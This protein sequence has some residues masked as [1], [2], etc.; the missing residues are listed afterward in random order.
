MNDV[1]CYLFCS[2]DIVHKGFTQS[3]RCG[4]RAGEA[5]YVQLHS[6]G[7]HLQLIDA[8]SEGY[9]DRGLYWA[10]SSP[11]VHFGF[12]HLLLLTGV[13]WV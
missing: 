1:D 2:F 13:S 12:P 6:P 3:H 7:W 8:M 5:A 11:Q 9:L 4:I 10:H